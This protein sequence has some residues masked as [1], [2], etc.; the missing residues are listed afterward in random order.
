MTI[1]IIEKITGVIVF[2][3]MVTAYAI[4][5]TMLALN[6]LP[7]TVEYPEEQHILGILK[8]L[9][10][11]RPTKQPISRVEKL[12]FMQGEIMKKYVN[13]KYIEMTPEEVAEYEALAQEVPM[14][15]PTA[16]ERLEALESAMLELIGVTQNG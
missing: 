16:E 12:K 14:P 2:Y 1:L 3:I 15:E 11:G 5:L 6:A 13:G 7:N 4:V 10:S 9:K 8:H